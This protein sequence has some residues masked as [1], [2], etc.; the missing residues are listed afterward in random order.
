MVDC[1][2]HVTQWGGWAGSSGLCLILTVL[3][4]CGSVMS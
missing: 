4:L 3:D 1:K 2:Q